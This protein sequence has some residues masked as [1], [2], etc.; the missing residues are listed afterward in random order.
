MKKFWCLRFFIFC[1]Y[2]GS[3]TTGWLRLVWWFYHS[4]LA[5]KKKPILLSPST[6]YVQYQH[7]NPSSWQEPTLGRLFVLKEM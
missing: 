7:E 2:A 1:K 4:S 5:K 6:L 3:F